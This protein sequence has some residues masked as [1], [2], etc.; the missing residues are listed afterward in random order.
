MMTAARMHRALR[1]AGVAAELHVQEAAG[2]GGF[3]GRA[4]ED[5]QRSEEIRRFLNEHWG[6]AAR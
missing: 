2:H 3:L 4:P 1:V 6:H 5:R